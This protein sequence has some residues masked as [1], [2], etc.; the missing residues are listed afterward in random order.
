MGANV[1]EKK[2]ELRLHSFICSNAVQAH[3]KNGIQHL[4]P[5]QLILKQ[6]IENLKLIK[7]HTP[8]NIKPP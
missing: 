2:L 6:I 7:S 8:E 4:R 1:V 3:P 5:I